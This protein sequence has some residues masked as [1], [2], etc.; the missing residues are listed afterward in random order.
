MRIVPTFR[1]RHEEHAA[2]PRCRLLLDRFDQQP[3]DSPAAVGLRD[4]ER[5]ELGG[6]ALVL[7][8]RRDVQVWARPT[9]S[10]SASATKTRSPT[11]TSRSRREVTAAPPAG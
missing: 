4:D 10:P 11:I 9:T 1:R 6:R 5:T 2:I 3:A 7:D 8:R